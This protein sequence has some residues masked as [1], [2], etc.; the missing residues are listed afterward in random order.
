VGSRVRVGGLLGILAVTFALVARVDAEVGPRAHRVRHAQSAPSR[1]ARWPHLVW[2]DNFNG[3]AGSEPNP[4]KWSFDTGGGGWGNEELE[5]YTSRS[6][7]AELD[8]HGHLVITARAETHTGSDGVTR[9]YTSA[10]LQMLHK[11]EFEYG[12]VEARIKVPVGQGLLPAFWMLG[13]GANYPGGWPASG[14]IDTMEVRGSQP[15]VVNGTIHGPWSSARH[16]MGGSLRSR[17]SLASGFHVYGVEWTPDR[18]SFMLDGSVYETITPADLP[19]GAAWPFGHPFFLLLDL[20]VGGRW[21]GLPSPTTPFP[22]KMIVDW[23][24]V[25]Q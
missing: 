7:N 15:Y 1:A 23:V 6:V 19:K 24:R 14:E 11:F 3:S 18:I 9:N 2:S 21:A 25:W 16:G 13:N 10:R 8:G 17:T 22:A 4:R 5:Y 12:L 20:A